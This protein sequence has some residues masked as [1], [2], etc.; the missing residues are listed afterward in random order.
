MKTIIYRRR[1][2]GKGEYRFKGK[3]EHSFLKVK[4]FKGKR[5]GSEL[6]GETATSSTLKLKKWNVS[7]DETAFLI[8]YLFKASQA[9]PH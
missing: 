6:N 9:F 1:R 5:C 8:N 4:N 7:F 2:D 3:D